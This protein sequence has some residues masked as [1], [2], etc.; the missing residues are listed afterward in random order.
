MGTRRQDGGQLRRSAGVRH[1]IGYLA[2]IR[3]SFTPGGT[4]GGIAYDEAE[5][6]TIVSQGLHD[7]PV[8]TVLVEQSVLG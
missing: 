3:P 8:N 6:R 4:G 2:I 7:S 5:F 1:S